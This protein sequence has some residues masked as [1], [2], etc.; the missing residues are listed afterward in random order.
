MLVKSLTLSIPFGLLDFL[1]EMGRKSKAAQLQAIRTKRLH[2]LSELNF[3]FLKGSM[4]AIIVPFLEHSAKNK[5]SPTVGEL[6]K[7]VEGSENMRYQARFRFLLAVSLPCYLKRVAIRL[8]NQEISD[9]ASALF[10]PI[11]FASNHNYYRDFYHLRFMNGRF[12]D[13]QEDVTVEDPDI[14]KFLG[15]ENVDTEPTLKKYSKKHPTQNIKYGLYKS[16][17]SYLTESTE[18]NDNHQGGDFIQ[19]DALGRVTTFLKRGKIFDL[20]VFA[21][22]V[23]QSQAY[24]ISQRESGNFCSNSKSRRPKYENE[25][26]SLAALILEKNEL[27]GIAE[28]LGDWH[29]DIFDLSKIGFENYRKYFVEKIKAVPT[30]SI[31]LK[32]AFITKGDFEDYNKIE[33][34]TKAQIAKEINIMIPQIA[35]DDIN[36]KSYYEYK[37]KKSKIKKDEL[38]EMYHEIRS[39][40]VLSSFAEQEELDGTSSD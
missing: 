2:T 8:N 40:L 20:E 13:T 12:E 25:V 30:T 15:S 17:Y 5:C 1:S 27:P 36:E 3:I 33:N 32:P 37:A 7:F 31:K 9:G 23:R 16:K 39:K 21:H 29:K 18:K 4:S 14:K 6:Y 26:Q 34:Q 19:E 22:A 24:Q 10:F 28:G 11:A 38:I 35:F